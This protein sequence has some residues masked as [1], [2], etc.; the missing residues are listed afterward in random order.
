VG[1][2]HPPDGYFHEQATIAEEDR[3]YGGCRALVMNIDAST[4]DPARAQACSNTM[5]AI[6]RSR[7]QRREEVDR[8]QRLVETENQRRQL[9]YLQ[10]QAEANRQW[11]EA[12]VAHQRRMDVLRALDSI[13]PAPPVQEQP[14]FRPS[15]NRSVNT[16]R[17][18]I[19]Q[20]TNCTSQ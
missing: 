12:Q 10:A 11:Q 18:T 3:V 5:A 20:F 15:V 6:D 19:G 14:I 2:E 4:K 7:T 1:A 13:H 9:E 8:R 16:T 17:N